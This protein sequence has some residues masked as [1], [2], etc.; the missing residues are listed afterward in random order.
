MNAQTGLKTV[1]DVKPDRAWTETNAQDP[2]AP[3]EKALRRIAPLWP[4]DRFVAVNPFL[5]LDDHSFGDAVARIEQV[6]GGRMLMDRAF[7]AEALKTGRIEDL[8]IA[9]ALAAAGTRPGLPQSVA[10]VKAALSD[11][12]H[13]PA[14]TAPIK[15]VAD[16]AA[17]L[18]GTDWVQILVQHISQSAAMYFGSY[19]DGPGGTVP[20][21]GF[22]GA[23]RSMVVADRTPEVLGLKGARRHAQH[24]PTDAR[25]MVV[26]GLGLLGLTGAGSER[27]CHRLLMSVSGWAGYARHL[28]WEAEL[29]G[30]DDDHLLEL[31]AAR[32]GSEVILRG[33]LFDDIDMS[34]LWSVE[35]SRYA[36]D[37]GGSSDRA[38]E[39]LLLSAYE[40]A[41]QR[42]FVLGLAGREATPATL[43]PAV[44]AAFCID[45]R[46]EVFRRAF[47]SVSPDIETIGFAGFFGLPLEHVPLGAE[48]GLSHCPVL[49]P[50][51]ITAREAASSEAENRTLT[52]SRQV[53]RGLFDAWSKA[54]RTSVSSFPFVEVAGLGY[55]VK[56]ATDALGLTRPVEDPK[57]AGLTPAEKARLGPGAD[58]F[59]VQD[60]T[61]G[62]GAAQRI[63]IATSILKGMSLTQRFAPLVLL[64]GHG[65]STVNNPHASGLDCGAC[66]GQSGEVNARVAAAILNDPEVRDGLAESGLVIPDDTLFVGALHDTTTD[67]VTLFADGAGS[68]GHGAALGDCREW[69]A[70]AGRIARLERMPKL[71]GADPSDPLAAVQARARDWSQVRPEWGLA[72]CAAFVAAPR[73]RTAGLD[74]DGRVFLHSYDWTSDPEFAVLDLIMTAPMVVASWINLQYYGSSVD[75]GV[76]GSGNKTLHNAVGAIGVFEGNGGDLR[77]G[78]PWQSVHDGERLVHEPMRLS[79]FIEAPQAAIDGVIERHEAVGRLVRN[80]WIALFS[81]DNTGN[82]ARRCAAPDRW[83]PV[84]P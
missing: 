7:F 25:E 22:Y 4:L 12:Q 24:L 55:A 65:A 44:Q 46:S 50:A 64:V 23:W 30:G 43:R 47:E 54:K 52:Q 32:L 49:V 42:R 18:T 59:A 58:L 60:G 40:R 15:T 39:E 8:D 3:M 80:G 1:T 9:D 68:S 76:F 63:Q 69:L 70:A 75:N 2:M 79:V 20:R 21:S 28:L 45:V 6:S 67:E 10:E 84:E 27:Y 82:A 74:L 51:G 78:L 66:G 16:L 17:A 77:T 26:E 14:A 81:L 34:S 13:V 31:L 37:A 83:E 62:I 11:H 71:N 33:S 48:R 61:H 53:R 35:R 38:L 36:S 29:A 41:W 57:R 73:A 19:A 56:L 72:G 5:G